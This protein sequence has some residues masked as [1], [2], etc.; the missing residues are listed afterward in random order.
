MTMLGEPFLLDCTVPTAKFGGEGIPV[1]GL[2]LG[3]GQGPTSPAKGPLNVSSYYD[4]LDNVMLP[5]FG[6]GLFLF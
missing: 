2:L 4:I 3:F 1:M 6:K 5:I